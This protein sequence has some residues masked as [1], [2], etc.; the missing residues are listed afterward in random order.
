M[1]TNQPPVPPSYSTQPSYR[2]A[3]SGVFGTK[4]PS[5]VAFTF[6]VL[7]FFLPFIDIKCNNM[8][9]KKVSGFEL[10]KGFEKPNEKSG[11]NSFMNDIKPDDNTTPKTK[12]DKNEPNM[13]AIA[14]MALGVLG[15]LLSLPNAK[16]AMGA[17]MV[18]GVASAGALIGLMIDVK[19]KTKIDLPN[20]GNKTTTDDTLGLNKLG[21]QM[22]GSMGITVDFT[23][24]FYIAIIAFL[25]AAF[26]CYKRMRSKP[27]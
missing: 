13:Y 4:I 23:P 11:N 16:G 14:A 22:A 2:P 26:F 5:T 6:G 25:A 20:M 21:D 7:L 9:L 17:A 19:K 15:L 24:W 18:T 8:S 12:A 3:S 10:A 1:D 27:S